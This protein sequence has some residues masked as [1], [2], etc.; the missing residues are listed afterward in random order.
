[1]IIKKLNFE[2]DKQTVNGH[3]YQKEIFI[4]ALEKSLEKGLFVY[5]N[6]EESNR[7]ANIIGK[8]EKYTEANSQISLEI[9]EYGPNEY[10]TL[11]EYV[12]TGGFGDLDGNKITNYTLSFVFLTNDHI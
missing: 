12:S 1:M 9:K 5:V 8:V 7:E 11:T 3:I 4:P 2:L 6:P 10:M